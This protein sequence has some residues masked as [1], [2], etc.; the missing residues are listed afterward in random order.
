MTSSRITNTV[1]SNYEGNPAITPQTTSILQFSEVRP[2]LEGRNS[3]VISALDNNVTAEGIT[4][5]YPGRQIQLA[6]E[7]SEGGAEFSR[8]L[9]IAARII[10]RNANVH[11]VLICYH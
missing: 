11:I 3:A 1:R 7:I 9:V 5:S 8:Y 4:N 2:A 10:G 6:V